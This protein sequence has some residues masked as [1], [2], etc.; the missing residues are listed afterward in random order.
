MKTPDGD[1]DRWPDPA[2]ANTRRSVLAQDL[3]VE[4]D[5]TSSGPVDVHGKIIGSMRAPDTVIGGSGRVEGSAVANDLSVLGA[6]S[7]MISARNVRLAPSA[8]VHADI[9]HERIAVEAGAELEG[10]L[11]SRA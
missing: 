8:V 9:S 4:G 7:R 10:S 1:L 2:D 6:V 5:A 3:V 11:Q